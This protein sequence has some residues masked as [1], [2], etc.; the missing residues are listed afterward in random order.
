MKELL[1]QVIE[2]QKAAEANVIK[3][4]EETAAMRSQL[5]SAKLLD[6][7]PTPMRLRELET[8]ERLA[9]KANLQI[10]VGSDKGLAENV[11]K[12]I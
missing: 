12:L 6:Q 4:R 9:E 10:L 7:T 5:N 8:L 1:N 2:A 3:C 11:T